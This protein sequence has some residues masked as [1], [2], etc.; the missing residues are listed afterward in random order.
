LRERPELIR[1]EYLS[2]APFQDR[3]LA[4]PKISV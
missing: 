4:L 3:L 2:A 1:V